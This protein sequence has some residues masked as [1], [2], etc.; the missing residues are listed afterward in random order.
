ME[1]KRGVTLTIFAVLFGL[2][3]ISNFMKPLK[4]NGDVGFVFL[5]TK[6]SGVPNMI[7]GPLFGLLLAAYAYG[8][9][10][11]RKFALP[12]AYFYAG[13][14]ILNLALYVAKTRGSG[15]GPSPIG[16]LLYPIIAIG[17]SSGAAIILHRRKAELT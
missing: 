16:V 15:F 14:V 1:K 13:Y 4:M 12:I 7:M 2:L 8:I 6:L 3:A 11:M 17:V 10:T 9:W 5:G